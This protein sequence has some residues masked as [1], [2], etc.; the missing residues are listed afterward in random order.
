MFKHDQP[1]AP[2][3]AIAV[4]DA[5]CPIDW[6]TLFIGAYDVLDAMTEAEIAV[7]DDAKIS[8]GDFRRPLEG[9]EEAHPSLAIC[10]G[11][12]MLPWR[13]DIEDDETLVRHIVLHHRIDIP[14]VECRSKPVFKRADR[15]LV[16]RSHR[17]SSRRRCEGHDDCGIT[18]CAHR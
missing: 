3:L 4:G 6:V 2:D 16:V 10:I 15:C 8:D 1:A 18:D 7:H 12:E 11:A 5:Y 14:G 13:H 17:E 9:C